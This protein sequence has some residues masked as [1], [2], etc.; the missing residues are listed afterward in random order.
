[1]EETAKFGVDNVALLSPYRQKTDTG[2]NALNERIRLQINPPDAAKKEVV[3]GKRAFRVGDKVM[4]TKN[5]EDINNGDVGYITEISGSGSETVVKIDFGDGRMAEYDIT[6]LG[7]LDLGYAS[8]IHKSQGSEYQS[9]IIN[10]Q[11]AHAIMLVRPLIYTAITRAKERVI[12]V[13]NAAP[14]VLPSRNR[15][16]K[17][18]ELY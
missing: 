5:R 10:L 17:N 6:E 3:L 13:G 1:M 9:V 15:T 14:C 8:T 12:I 4:Q 2:V 16:R 18:E 11:C 7:L